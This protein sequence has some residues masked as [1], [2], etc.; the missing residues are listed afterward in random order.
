MK[1]EELNKLLKNKE[2]S[3]LTIEELKQII[4]KVNDNIIKI[5][6][7]KILEAKEFGCDISLPLVFEEERNDDKNDFWSD[8]KT[9]FDN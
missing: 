3:E 2:P 4:P 1:E 5:N 9:P 7:E 6:L 8:M